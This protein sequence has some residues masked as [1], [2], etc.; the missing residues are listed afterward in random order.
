MGEKNKQEE[1]KTKDPEQAAAGAPAPSNTTTTPAVASTKAK[2]AAKRKR[3]EVARTL[4]L[5]KKDVRE[6][7]SELTEGEVSAE[8]LAS[9]LE[10]GFIRDADAPIPPSQ[11][12]QT[13]AFDRLA[14]VAQKIGALQREGAEY[15]LG[16]RTFTGL[17][18]FRSQVSLDELEAAIVAEVNG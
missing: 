2:P 14:R 13:A 7:G 17:T 15:R 5:G 16:E 18:E 11:A 8:A 6:P 10:R 12:E 9:L 3:Y 4:N 1:N